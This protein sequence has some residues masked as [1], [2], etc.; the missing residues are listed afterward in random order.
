MT[1]PNE[2][3]LSEMGLVTNNI[4][5]ISLRSSKESFKSIT[6]ET[7]KFKNDKMFNL[8][9]AEGCLTDRNGRKEH[10]H[11]LMTI[12]SDPNLLKSPVFAH[13]RRIRSDTS[14]GS[15]ISQAKHNVNQILN[16]NK[17]LKRNRAS[18]QGV[19]LSWKKLPKTNK[20]YN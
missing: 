7:A 14:N 19:E 4:S 9:H 10:K 18:N 15:V 20:V 2:L 3:K 16:R 11:N 17:R 13:H 12:N 6:V 1:N 8:T 5:A